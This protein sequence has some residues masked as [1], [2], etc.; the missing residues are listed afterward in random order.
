MTTWLLS[1]EGA[2]PGMTVAKL[3]I[4]R[5]GRPADLRVHPGRDW[6]TVLSGT[7]VLRLASGRSW[8]RP[9][10]RPSSRRWSRTRS[11][12]TAARPRCSASS[13]TTA[14]A[15]TCTRGRVDLTGP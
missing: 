5:P 12:R 7:V 15:R 11:A 4:T 3:R 8:S 1:R 9:V 2:P 10:R 14:S 6:F 13:T